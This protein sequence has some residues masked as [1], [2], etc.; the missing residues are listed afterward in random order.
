MTRELS[1]TG[2]GAAEEAI[3]VVGSVALDTVETPFGRAEEVV[4]GSAVYFGAA[5]S[6]FGDVQLVGVVGDDYPVD[7]LSF[8]RERGADLDGLEVASGR[9]FR[10]S[11]V[12]E[13]D[14]NARRT[15]STE[16]GVFADF[17]PSVPDAFRSA[18]WV[19]LGNIDPQLQHGVL[20][21]IEEPRLVACDTM[22]YWIERDR[23]A[24]LALLERIDM[25]VI[26]DAEARELSEDHNLA[27]AARWILEQGPSHVVIK[28]GEHGA[29]LFQEEGVFFVPGFP[30][31]EIFDPT[32]AGDAFAGGLLGQLARAGTVTERELRRAM[33]FGCALGSFACEAFGPDRLRDLS[34]HEVGGRVQAF[35]EMTRF[36]H[37]MPV[38]P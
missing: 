2:P 12:Y 5:A 16:L 37:E 18:R 7:R 14:L 28:K 33:V 17:Q 8:L 1:V 4:G 11:G 3:L 35:L 23:D 20:D 34:V 10:W 6:L 36:E 13:Y 26:N 19:F 31:E 25:L 38:G 15:L 30:L 9:S 32:G 22:N 27:R 24:L 21:Q 29:V